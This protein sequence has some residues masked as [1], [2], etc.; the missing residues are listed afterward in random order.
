MDVQM[1]RLLILSAEAAIYR[2]LVESADLSQLQVMIATDAESAGPLLADCNIILGDP[3]LVSKVLEQAPALQWV[4]SSWAGVDSLCR[5]GQRRDYLLT[6]AKGVFGPLMS[7]YMMAYLLMFERQVLTMLDNQ[8]K[9][10]WQPLAY[11]PAAEITLG[12]AGLGSIGKHLSKTARHFGIR[13]IGMN[14]SGKACEYVETVYT[15]DQSEAFFEQ[16][17]YIILTLPDTPETRHF[18]NAEKLSLMK[19]SA[20]LMNVGRGG[21][22]NEEHLIDAL[23]KGVIAAAVLD[24]FEQEPL[25]I[26]STL[27]ELPNVYITPHNAATSFPADIAGIFI[28][29]YK[30][31]IRATDLQYVIDFEAGY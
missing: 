11:R 28:K 19:P 2:T 3:P 16:S 22:V 8:R 4:Q 12:V 29:N 21:I 26:D 7:E 10:H 15:H 24:V 17:D 13:V 27:W 14:R 20:V 6:G 18:I 25:A 31:F 1:N 30:R 9:K 23:R 5:K